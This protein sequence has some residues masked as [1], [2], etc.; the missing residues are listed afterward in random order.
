MMSANDRACAP[1]VIAC[2][3]LSLP[4]VISAASGVAVMFC[5]AIASR[6]SLRRTTEAGCG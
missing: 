3:G 1:V 4:L 5:S 2:P 6:T